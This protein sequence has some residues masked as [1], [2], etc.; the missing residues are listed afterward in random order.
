MG[1]TIVAINPV[2]QDS[3]SLWLKRRVGGANVPTLH[4]AERND[5]TA[6]LEQNDED[7]SEIFTSKWSYVAGIIIVGS[8]ILY[9]LN[10]WNYL[11]SKR[12]SRRKRAVSRLRR[13]IQTISV[14]RVPQM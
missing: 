14:R 9:L 2:L 12:H 5:I 3:S 6:D 8:I 10:R 1:D 7:N 11:I 13:V 4:H